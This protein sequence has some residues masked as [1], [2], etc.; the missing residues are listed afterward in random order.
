M[1]LHL[2]KDFL[3]KHPLNSTVYLRYYHL[4]IS[5]Y[6]L[7]GVL[8]YTVVGSTSFSLDGTPIT[9]GSGTTAVINVGA[10]LERAVQLPGTYV[11]SLADIDRVLALKSPANPLMN[12]GLFRVSGID[13]PSN[14]LIMV[15]RSWLETPIAETGV[16]WKLFENE[17]LVTANFLNGSNGNPEAGALTKYRGDGSATT[18][19]IILQSPHSTNWQLRI[20]AEAPIDTNGSGGQGAIG[21]PC[22]FA[23]GFGGNSA[24]DFANA[25]QHLHHPQFWNLGGDQSILS[26]TSQTVAGLGITGSDIPGRYYMWGDDVTG[27][28]MIICRQHGSLPTEGIVVFGLPEDEEQPL[29]VNPVHRLFVF[30]S[31]NR[32]NVGTGTQITL[33]AEA[34]SVNYTVL[35]S[36][37]GLGNQPIT[38]TAGGWAYSTGQTYFSGLMNDATAA[39]DVYLGATTLTSYD[40]YAG[41]WDTGVQGGN[42]T[43]FISLEPRR[44]GRLPFARRGRENFNAFSTSVDQSRSWLYFASGIFCPWSG[45]IIP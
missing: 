34:G 13:V 22:S 15:A 16:T 42:L 1:T 31:T 38:C 20:C 29:P 9:K 45:S 26:R 7:R 33:K 4:C 2:C 5:S 8:G 11:V 12:S 19:R 36:A 23:P 43:P 14:S 25:G 10:G 21:A 24:G 44:L 30:G 35:G 41:T 3:A 40:L 37:F 17:G 6:F 32:V 28:C 18:S 27:T 39:D